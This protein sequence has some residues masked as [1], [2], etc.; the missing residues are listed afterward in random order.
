MLAD[1]DNGRHDTTLRLFQRVSRMSQEQQFL[2][3]RQLA[4]ERVTRELFQLIVALPESEQLQLLEQF[5]RME[6]GDAGERTLRLEGSEPRMR[7]YP[8]KSCLINAD[9]RVRGRDCRSYILDISI[10]GVFVETHERFTVGEEVILNFTLPDHRQPF[11]LRGR[12]AWSGPEG[13]GVKFEPLP[14]SQGSA[15]RRF[16]E[17]PQ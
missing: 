17:E 10:G 15:I 16:V 3:L 5:G 2:L 7:E 11:S 14:P 1:L 6:E 13:F 12:I 8:R 9:Y 4:G